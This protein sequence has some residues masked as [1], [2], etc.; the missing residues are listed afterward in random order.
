MRETFNNYILKGY[1]RKGGKCCG[2]CKH[3][4]PLFRG[5][6]LC[7]KNSDNVILISVCNEYEKYEG[8]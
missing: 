5:I 4:R 1:K 2:T 6:F 3:I 7:N 8:E